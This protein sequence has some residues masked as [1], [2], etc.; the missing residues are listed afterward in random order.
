VLS[1]DETEANA[2]LLSVYGGK[3]TTY[4]RL[5]ES[6]LE[7]LAR[8]LPLAKEKAGWTGRAPLP[9]GDFPVDGFE[10]LV[11][12]L[13]NDFPFLDPHD[14]RRMARC[15]GTRARAMLDGARRASDLGAHFGAGLTAREVLYL[16]R[17]E[18]AVTLDDL[19]WRRSKL[20]LHL[21]DAGK[22]ALAHFLGDEAREGAMGAMGL[23]I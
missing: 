12:D 6:A 7:K 21:D 5:A 22:A 15:Y 18:W 4:R 10:T 8:W 19:L 14:L 23:S 17:E 1:L 20:G 2:P 3:I 16:M 11:G 9:G 13:G